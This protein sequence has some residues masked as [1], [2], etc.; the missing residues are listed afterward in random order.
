MIF[1]DEI[2]SMLIEK[3]GSDTEIQQ[4]GESV[5]VVEAIAKAFQDASDFQRVQKD[6]NDI[7]EERNGLKDKYKAA[8]EQ[9]EK[10]EK[11]SGDTGKMAQENQTLQG[12][13]N[14][15]TETIKGLQGTLDGMQEETKQA[16][17]SSLKANQS[18][19]VISE[20][21]KNGIEGKLAEDALL[22]M[23]AR[24][25]IKVDHETSTEQYFAQDQLGQLQQSTLESVVKNFGESHK[26]FVSGSKKTGLGENHNVQ[27]NANQSTDMPMHQMLQLEK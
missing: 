6:K 1:S 25:L 8:K 16:K 24:G 12:R 10:L 7:V 18:K 2:K 9:L 22:L 19:K 21:V 5:K 26:N 20:L 23:E 11:A 3:V 4:N 17:L 13:V 15:L 27:G 14:D